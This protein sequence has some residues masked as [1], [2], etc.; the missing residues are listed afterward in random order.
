MQFNL[1]DQWTHLLI[2]D[3]LEPSKQLSADGFAGSLANQTNLAIKGI[4]AVQ[5]MSQMSTVVGAND[6]AKH[7]S[8]CRAIPGLFG[9]WMLTRLS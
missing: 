8:V 4:I 1:L 6:D 2:R 3:S 9:G 5:A 7:Y